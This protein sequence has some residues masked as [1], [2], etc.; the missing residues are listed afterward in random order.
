MSHDNQR[1]IRIC[2]TRR[3]RVRG[4]L[5]ADDSVSA[6]LARCP[7]KCAERHPRVSRQIMKLVS[8]NINFMFPHTLRAFH[9]RSHQ[10]QSSK[11]INHIPDP[12]LN[13]LMTRSIVPAF[14][15]RGATRLLDDVT[16]VES[17]GCVLWKTDAPEH[18]MRRSYLTQ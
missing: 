15:E 4:S 14:P 16:S 13:E 7:V 11:N 17:F 9:G 18:I 3:P 8:E 2:S 1:S 12:L 5:R 6:D 10:R